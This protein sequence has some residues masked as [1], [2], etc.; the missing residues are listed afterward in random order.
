MSKRWIKKVEST[1][2]DNSLVLNV[3][4]GISIS[5]IIVCAIA[6]VIT[7]ALGFM[8]SLWWFIATFYC[9]IL[10]GA[11]AGVVRWLYYE[12]W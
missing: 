7:I 3:V 1:L 2:E 6:T 4:S 9:V 12:Y 10:C 8:V 11:T 5:F